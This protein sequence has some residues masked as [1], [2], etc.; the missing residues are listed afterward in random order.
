MRAARLPVL[1]G[2][3]ATSKGLLLR[4]AMPHRAAPTTLC[5][6]GR[7]TRIHGAVASAM[8]GA[9]PRQIGSTGLESGECAP[10]TVVGAPQN[11]RG[12]AALDDVSSEAQL[13]KPRIAATL[14]CALPMGGCNLVIHL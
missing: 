11:P 1:H 12:V 5:A 4:Q 10:R 9:S 8:C 13:R 3:S 2:F 6:V 7:M 14:P